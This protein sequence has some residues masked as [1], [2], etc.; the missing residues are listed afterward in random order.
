M[1]QIV[2]SHVDDAPWMH[3]SPLGAGE[4]FSKV[5]LEP[6]PRVA[7]LWYEP[8]YVFPAH[9]HPMDEVLYVLNG[10]M[11]V[12][13]H[14]LKRGS[15]IFIPKETV[16]GPEYTGPSGALFL[17]VELW[18]TE[19]GPPGSRSS[20]AAYEPWTGQMGSDGM[21]RSGVTRSPVPEGEMQPEPAAGARSVH[22]DDARWVQVQ[23]PEEGA[24]LFM[25]PL[26]TGGPSVSQFW[27]PQDSGDHPHSH[28]I[29]ELRFILNGEMDLAGRRVTPRTA[30]FVPK[31][32]PFR[33][34][35]FSPGGV[36]LLRLELWDT[37]A[38]R[39]ERPGP[40]V[41]RESRTWEGPLTAD[42]VPDLDGNR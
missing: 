2:Y 9:R 41:K 33:M 37:H 30:I 32:T 27:Y 13:G 15:S 5:V 17:R 3:L 31:N 19:E 40:P 26:L 22:A 14:L 21:P 38:G 24:D 11:S 16:Y 4:L 28:E 6:R 1:K 10:E 34:T 8:G 36:K 39:P 25:R 7:Q 35:N 20:K 42:G 12:S 18:D 23:L 29:D